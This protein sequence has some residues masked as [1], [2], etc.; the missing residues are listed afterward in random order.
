MSDWIYAVILGIVEGLTEFIPVSSTGM[1]LLT[2][3]ALGLPDA[4]WDTFIVLIQLGAI[5]AV[6]VLYFRRLWN[7]VLAP[8]DRSAGARAS[9]SASSS[10]SCPAVVLG[11]A[12]ARLHQA[13]AVREPA[14]DLHLAD[15]R[16]RGAAADRPL[17]AAS[18]RAT[19]PWPC[20][21]APRWRSASSSAWRWSP[22]SR[23]RARPSSARML[24][25]V[26]KRAAAEFSFF[27]AIPAMLGAFILDAWKSRARA[28]R[29]PRRAGR[30]RLRGLVRRR[31]GGDPRHAGDRH[32]PRLRALRL[33]ADRHRRRLA[34][35]AADARLEL[36]RSSASGRS[37][38]P[39]SPPP[40]ARRPALGA[41]SARRASGR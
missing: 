1:L 41:A 20:R 17:R 7:V 31:P 36:R 12:A 9:R 5:L 38:R 40:S 30:H 25:G 4:F 11:F 16:R 27:L 26:E 33:A 22:A 32:P 6:V 8:A 3:Q 35:C 28:G 10:P 14:A 13:G 19:T 18:R 29:R 21:S 37:R 23:A 24:M 34:C 15:R 2:K 39:A